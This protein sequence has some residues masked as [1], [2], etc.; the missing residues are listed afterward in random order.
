MGL[1]LAG[2]HGRCPASFTLTLLGYCSR[3]SMRRYTQ[4]VQFLKILFSFGE[5]YLTLVL[6]G[7]VSISTVTTVCQDLHGALK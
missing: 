3:E 4:A 6:S 1:L 5:I 2:S 7:D